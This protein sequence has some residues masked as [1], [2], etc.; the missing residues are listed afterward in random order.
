MPFH[1]RQGIYFFILKHPVPAELNK[2]FQKTL[3]YIT[4]SSG[5][6][7]SKPTTD[8][9]QWGLLEALQRQFGGTSPV[10][11]DLSFEPQTFCSLHRIKLLPPPSSRKSP[12]IQYV[13]RTRFTYA[14]N[15]HFEHSCALRTPII[16]WWR[17]G[18]LRNR[19][20]SGKLLFSSSSE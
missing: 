18:A 17:C 3:S 7:M 9:A 15:R 10:P 2:L 8:I 14:K 20:R 12:R 5:S 16:R 13:G 6:L 19:V 11:L 4:M 1:F